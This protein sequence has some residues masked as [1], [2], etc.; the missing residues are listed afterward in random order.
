MEAS[1]DVTGYEQEWPRLGAPR[2]ARKTIV[3]ALAIFGSA[4]FTL[5]VL[6]TIGARSPGLPDLALAIVVAPLPIMLWWAHA[7]AAD[8]SRRPIA[9]LASAATL[10]LA[11]LLVWE[12]YAIAGGSDLSRS[13]AI[14][15]GL[16]AAAQVLVILA[17]ATVIGS[18]C[19]LRLVVLDTSVITA[20]G[21]A[22][23]ALFA[24]RGVESPAAFLPV[25]SAVLGVG[26]LMLIVSAALRSSGG[27]PLSIGIFGLAEVTL[28]AGNVIHGYGAAQGQLVDERWAALAWGAGAIVAAVAASVLVFGIDRPVRPPVRSAIPGHA[29]AARP[30]I[31]LWTL[32]LTLALGV[33]CFG[34]LSG[35]HR[36]ALVALIAGAAVGLAL[37]LRARESIRTAETAYRRLDQTLAESERAHDALVLAN[38]ELAD[39]N[40]QSRAVQVAFASLLNMAD[41][42][43]Q[44]RIR[45]LIEETGGELAELLEEQL[46]R[47]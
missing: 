15:D 6:A 26:A 41:E 38:E 8:R 1:V 13:A 20:V 45:E 16:F 44:G 7:N 25:G 32:A 27:V 10:W 28:I 24:R 36:L 42:R 22:L 4:L 43:S 35:S 46:E 11:G 37:A 29:A 14:S 9:L 18:S 21:L 12:A 40:V 33:S 31:L 17:L 2:P 23:G 34:L 39:A 5:D 30:I 3:S 19:S 47:G